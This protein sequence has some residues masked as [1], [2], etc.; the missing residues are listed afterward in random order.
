MFQAE[1]WLGAVFACLAC[2]LL[3]HVAAAE[4]HELADRVTAAGQFSADALCMQAELDTAQWFASFDALQAAAVISACDVVPGAGA[5][6]GAELSPQQTHS[7][8]I[9]TVRMQTLKKTTSDSSMPSSVHSASSGSWRWRAELPISGGQSTAITAAATGGTLPSALWPKA[10][11]LGTELTTND[12]IV[13]F[14]SPVSGSEQGVSLAALPRKCAPS[15]QLCTVTAA[16]VR[17]APAIAAAAPEIIGGPAKFWHVVPVGDVSHDGMPDIGVLAGERVLLQALSPRDTLSGRVQLQAALPS[18]PLDSHVLVFQLN[19]VS[20][21]NRPDA[22][23]GANL[24]IKQATFAKGAANGHAINY[25]AP[26]G[27]FLQQHSP[28]KLIVLFETGALKSASLARLLEDVNTPA[29]G[30]STSAFRHL[31]QGSGVKMTFFVPILAS[32]SSEFPV[33]TVSTIQVHSLAGLCSSSLAAAL[34]AGVA[35]RHAMHLP[36]LP[37]QDSGLVHAQSALVLGSAPFTA[38]GAPPASASGRPARALSSNPRKAVALTSPGDVDGDGQPDLAFIVASAE[39]YVVRVILSRD[40]TDRDSTDAAGSSGWRALIGS[41]G[42]IAVLDSA[43]SHNVVDFSDSQFRATVGLLPAAV[44]PLSTLGLSTSPALLLGNV[45]SQQPGSISQLY[46]AFLRWGFVQGGSPVSALSVTPLCVHAPCFPGGGAEE[47]QVL[48]A[49]PSGSRSQPAMFISVSHTSVTFGLIGASL[50]Q[51]GAPAIVHNGTWNQSDITATGSSGSVFRVAEGSLIGA[52]IPG[53]INGNG[54]PDVVL[55]CNGAGA[56]PA[57]HLVIMAMGAHF[58]PPLAFDLQ[59]QG[60]VVRG[61]SILMAAPASALAAAAGEPLDG[62]PP[63]VSPG[64]DVDGDGTPDLLMAFSSKKETVFGALLLQPSLS[65]WSVLHLDTSTR[66]ADSIATITVGEGVAQRTH[67]ALA[68]QASGKHARLALVSATAGAAGSSGFLVGPAPHTAA[69]PRGHGRFLSQQLAVLKADSMLEG[70]MYGD[71]FTYAGPTAVGPYLPDGSRFLFVAQPHAQDQFGEHGTIVLHRVRPAL[72]TQ[73]GT[74]VVARHV[75][76]LGA[77]GLGCFPVNGSGMGTSMVYLGPWGPSGSEALLAGAPAW[78]AGYGGFLVIELFLDINYELQY[79]RSVPAHLADVGVVKT[80]DYGQYAGRALSVLDDLNADGTQEVLFSAAGDPFS[81]CGC[82]GHFGIT[83]PRD[84]DVPGQLYAWDL[85]YINSTTAGLQGGNRTCFGYSLTAVG[86]VSGDGMVDFVVAAP[87]AVP[88]SEQLDDVSLPQGVLVLAHSMTGGSSGSPCLEVLS[89][90]WTEIAAVPLG[91]MGQSSPSEHFHSLFLAPIDAAAPFHRFTVL[92]GAASSVYSTLLTLEV[93]QSPGG[94]L[95]AVV[96]YMQSTSFLS[97][98]WKLGAVAEQTY[99]SAGWAGTSTP[100]AAFQLHD[101]TLRVVFGMLDEFASLEHTAV[102]PILPQPTSTT[103]SSGGVMLAKS[104]A[105]QS[106]TGAGG[107]VGGTSG[108]FPG[109]KSSSKVQMS[110]PSGGSAGSGG[111]AAKSTTTSS[112]GDITPTPTQPPVTVPNAPP[113]KPPL[114]DPGAPNT[115]APEDDFV[116]TG[117]SLRGM[118][119]NTTVQNVLDSQVENGFLLG[120]G[121]SVAWLGPGPAAGGVGTG[122]SDSGGDWAWLAVGSNGTLSIHVVHVPSLVVRGVLPV[123]HLAAGSPTWLAVVNKIFDSG[124]VNV[125][126][127]TWGHAVAPA[128]DANGDGVP[129]LIMAG[130]QDTVLLELDVFGS[131]L[132]A[133]HIYQGSF[134]SEELR[135]GRPTVALIA[136]HGTTP[137]HVLAVHTGVADLC[138]AANFNTGVLVLTG[139]PGQPGLSQALGAELFGFGEESLCEGFGTS[140]TSVGDFNR[141]GVPDIA[142]LNGNTGLV[143]LPLLMVSTPASGMVKL[144]ARNDVLPFLHVAASAVS[145]GTGTSAFGFAG[146]LTALASADPRHPVHLLTGYT[147]SQGKSGLAVLALGTHGITGTAQ[148]ILSGSATVQRGVNSSAAVFRHAISVFGGPD[149]SVLLVTG[150]P[151]SGNGTVKLFSLPSSATS[152]FMSPLLNPTT[153]SLNIAAPTATAISTGASTW[154]PDLDG[155]G[156]LDLVTGHP[157]AAGTGDFTGLATG[158]VLVQLLEGGLDVGGLSEQIDLS[159]FKV[160]KAG[161]IDPSNLGE[162]AGAEFGASLTVLGDLGWGPAPEILVGAPGYKGGAGCVFLVS[163]DL[164]DGALQYAVRR[165]AA[166]ADGAFG[167]A[168]AAVSV[169]GGGARVFISAPGAAN[170]AGDIFKLARI[171]VSPVPAGQGA[172]LPAAVHAARTQLA[173]LPSDV[174]DHPTFGRTLAV[175]S[176]GLP[177][178][179][180]AILFVGVPAYSSHGAIVVLRSDAFGELVS[181]GVAGHPTGLILPSSGRQGPP[182]TPFGAS[183]AL[184]GQVHT[185]AATKVTLVLGSEDASP[186]RSDWLWVLQLDLLP[187][188]VPGGLLAAALRPLELPLGATTQGIS[189]QHLSATVAP[190]GQVQL[191]AGVRNGSDSAAPTELALV[192]LPMFECNSAA[193][194][195]TSLHGG[196]VTLHPG[197]GQPVPAGTHGGAMTSP[198]DIDADGTL[199]IV[200]SGMF[201][202]GTWYISTAFPGGGV[203]VITPLEGDTAFLGELD[204]QDWAD[205]ASVNQLA[206][207]GDVNKDGV[208]DVLMG[209]R[210]DGR[211]AREGAVGIAF[212][213][214]DGMVT[215]ITAI[216]RPVVLPEAEGV[217]FSDSSDAFDGMMGAG[218]AVASLWDHEGPGQLALAVAS[219]FGSEC[220]WAV[221]KYNHGSTVDWETPSHQH[222]CPSAGNGTAELGSAL[223]LAWLPAGA[224]LSAMNSRLLPGEGVLV[225]AMQPL[226]D[227]FQPGGSTVVMVPIGSDLEP[228]VERSWTLTPAWGSTAFPHLPAGATHQVDFGWVLQAADV[229]SDGVLDLVTNIR[230]HTHSAATQL[231]ENLPGTAVL[232]L[233]GDGSLR[234]TIFAPMDSMQLSSASVDIAPGGI[235][236]LPGTPQRVPMAFHG[237]AAPGASRVARQALLGTGGAWRWGLRGPIVTAPG[238][239]SGF[240]PEGDGGTSSSPGTNI[241]GIGGGLGFVPGTVEGTTVEGGKSNGGGVP[242]FAPPPGGSAGGPFTAFGRSVA[243]VSS[244][245]DELTVAFATLTGIMYVL[246]TA[247]VSMATLLSGMP[248]GSATGTH[249]RTLVSDTDTGTQAGGDLVSGDF[250]GD[251]VVDFAQA[252]EQRLQFYTSIGGVSPGG[253]RLS[254]HNRAAKIGATGDEQFISMVSYKACSSVDRIAVLRL[255]SPSTKVFA[256]ELYRPVASVELLLNVSMFGNTTDGSLANLGWLPGW[257]G[258]VLAV[259]LNTGASIGYGVHL[260]DT[261]NHDQ[262]AAAF[263]TAFETGIPASTALAGL[264]SLGDLTGDG[265]PE[266]AVSSSNAGSVADSLLLLQM[267]SPPLDGG[268]AQA[269][270]FDSFPIAGASAVDADPPTDG[271]GS[272]LQAF[273]LPS[274]K[275]GLLVGAPAA[276]GGGGRVHFIATDKIIP[277]LA[278]TVPLLTVPTLGAGRVATAVLAHLQAGGTRA[279][280]AGLAINAST[281][282]QLAPS[283]HV[284]LAPREVYSAQLAL[285]SG[286]TQQLAGSD[287]AQSPTQEASL[288]RPIP[289]VDGDGL[290]EAVL[291]SGLTVSLHMSSRPSSELTVATVTTAGFSTAGAETKSRFPAAAVMLQSALEGTGDIERGL[292]V[293]LPEASFEDN[294]QAGALAYI[295]LGADG[296]LGQAC[297]ALYSIGNRG[298]LGASLLQLPAEHNGDNS[299]TA[300]IIVGAPGLSKGNGSLFA[301]YMEWANGNHHIVGQGCFLGR[302]LRKVAV[303]NILQGKPYQGVQLSG[304]GSSLLLLG[305]GADGA[306]QVLVGAHKTQPLTS[307]T[308]A[309]AVVLLTLQGRGISNVSATITALVLPSSTIHPPAA[310]PSGAVGGVAAANVMGAADL[311]LTAGAPGSNTAYLWALASHANET[312]TAARSQV[313]VAQLDTTGLNT[314]PQPSTAV[315]YRPAAPLAATPSASPSATSIAIGTFAPSGTPSPSTGSSPGSTITASPTASLSPGASPSTTAVP[316]PS[317][318]PAPLVLDTGDFSY[319]EERWWAFCPDLVAPGRPNATERLQAAGGAGV[320]VAVL[321]IGVLPGFWCPGCND[322]RAA[323]GSDEVAMCPRV[324][325]CEVGGPL[326]QDMRC[327]PGHTGAGCAACQSGWVPQDGSPC[328][329]CV[330]CDADSTVVVILLALGGAFVFGVLA[331]LAWAA[332]VVRGKVSQDLLFGALRIL[333]MYASLL[334]YIIAAF[335]PAEEGSL[336]MR[337]RAIHMDDWYEA[338]GRTDTNAHRQR[339]LASLTQDRS[340]ST[341]WLSD[342][343][344]YPDAQEETAAGFADDVMQFV[345]GISGA[346]PVTST[347]LTGCINSHQDFE[348]SATLNTSLMLGTFGVLLCIAVGFWLGK[349]YF[350]AACDRPLG[351]KPTRENVSSR[352]PSTSATANPMFAAVVAPASATANPMF[353]GRDGRKQIPVLSGT[354]SAAPGSKSSKENKN[355]EKPEAEKT[356]WT[357]R[358]LAWAGARFLAS[359]YLFLWAGAISASLQVLAP[360]LEAGDSSWVTAASLAMDINT[361]QHLVVLA[362]AAVAVFGFVIPLGL[363]AYLRGRGITVLDANSHASVTVAILTSGYRLQLTPVETRQLVQVQM[364]ASKAGR[365]LDTDTNAAVY[366][367]AQEV[368]RRMEARCCGLAKY[369]PSHGFA[370]VRQIQTVLVLCALWLLIEPISRAAVIILALAAAVALTYVLQPYALPELNSLDMQASIAVAIHVL[371]L[372]PGGWPHLNAVVWVMHA[373]TALLLALAVLRGVSQKGREMLAYVNTMIKAWLPELENDL[374]TADAADASSA[375]AAQDA[376]LLNSASPSPLA[377]LRALLVKLG[378]SALKRDPDSMRAQRGMSRMTSW[379][380][381]AEGA[382]AAI[383]ASGADSSTA[384]KSTGRK[385]N[386]AGGTANGVSRQ[387]A[388]E[389]FLESV[390]GKSSAKPDAVSSQ[391]LALAVQQAT[392]KRHAPPPKPTPTQSSAAGGQGAYKGEKD[393]PRKRLSLA[394][395]HAPAGGPTSVLFQRSSNTMA[396]MRTE[397][398]NA[399]DI[400]LRR[401]NAEAPTSVFAPTRAGVRSGRAG[402][403]R[404]RSDSQVA[405]LPSTGDRSHSTAELYPRGYS[406]GMATPASGRR[407]SAIDNRG[408]AGSVRI[409]PAGSSRRGTKG[410]GA[411]G[412]AAS[413]SSRTVS[414][415]RTTSGTL[416]SLQ[417]AAQKSTAGATARSSRRMGAGGNGPRRKHS[418]AAEFMDE[419]SLEV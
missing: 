139:G 129:D 98:A 155:N 191:A 149:G 231:N 176:V 360:R 58:T 256:L 59:T 3:S 187:G 326:Q 41:P 334:T 285:P 327:A 378:C 413:A 153:F 269:P 404:G 407:G 177:S 131:L 205:V 47:G 402:S 64:G 101:G 210:V 345:G 117:G 312:S 374:P 219:T 216:Q 310:C 192:L 53:D 170:T 174:L 283:L 301:F 336:G 365:K 116:I 357:V 4:S 74:H 37:R 46:V 314:D 145:F 96:E 9:C 399:E 265:M 24:P 68:T 130:P 202:D 307:G 375:E 237:F 105:K 196:Q 183:M 178:A 8:V 376:Q 19:T 20:T 128:G 15:R 218:M 341:T 250:N 21:K 308:S 137:F 331:Y 316:T 339:V 49:V 217:S 418:S 230:M 401:S 271:F 377:L 364:V 11:I 321:D 395:V 157:G 203:D 89:W 284:L 279:Y 215:S 419:A 302:R 303:D 163:L 409:A 158:T 180:N 222:A 141:D 85:T 12:I 379:K 182:P 384:G 298:H 194:H 72:G 355:T 349:L 173:D 382:V 224:L 416:R 363:M 293:G 344:A 414:V 22:E 388:V 337:T 330:R 252:F 88:A 362:V 255:F 212:L 358:V 66:G 84:G 229:D 261:G 259:L 403:V 86:D 247:V 164:A 268:I 221:S 354:S 104:S 309:G 150:V 262:L 333:G 405:D 123:S 30:S 195:A 171:F 124:D 289:D 300:V 317:A 184:A 79:G 94:E 415:S 112:G 304:L 280:V 342:A 225:F 114:S 18:P 111:T 83:S 232:F 385:G 71:N 161:T 299:N 69:T 108:L 411:D 297:I 386:A 264:V 244:V 80:G 292:L 396:S 109:G 392:A 394:T 27:A 99:G 90:T 43:G 91:L 152:P 119:T 121:T 35:V 288:W 408:R 335:A 31:P 1:C 193:G 281:A 48:A 254:S 410:G 400:E 65:G 7:S 246:K 78:D 127:I 188:P 258:Q 34:K 324:G 233:A 204:S 209:F 295:P 267:Q 40:S 249:V 353:A 390:A 6:F 175:T 393:T 380:A 44:A 39:W 338:C 220:R 134:A 154:L 77:H 100:R 387:S 140:V 290:P 67:I 263:T 329:P 348:R 340:N 238:G 107:P 294:P 383:D 332:V 260:L 206:P 17:F 412:K 76:Q 245:G 352:S 306:T 313:F 214:R 398:T 57:V 133:S 56:S 198:G 135:Q 373:I 113:M 122:G 251:G 185:P 167:T 270:R 356:T 159:L 38:S 102:M 29:A 146:S 97:P 371:V 274:G 143:I 347:A 2:V 273:Q 381:F 296:I 240:A 278:S 359:I 242:P 282:G 95:A 162:V 52:T 32:D 406:F 291:V 28:A 73:H 87:G 169:P 227:A 110:V 70:V 82:T 106:S 287:G 236:F 118:T 372:V 165:N 14:S 368:S 26:V 346:L 138:S 168:V 54:V 213:A 50:I 92:V 201:P 223:S 23:A 315:L 144:E 319:C 151:S 25:G 361:V 369:I 33:A 257:S 272:S 125:G 61:S 126:S 318:T 234:R 241:G 417:A 286:A 13:A 62:G 142:V 147:S 328:A 226:R 190:N 160:M 208:P 311:A 156:F 323:Y 322:A 16:A 228:H 132:N 166:V 243:V 181:F 55:V 266:L 45:L 235:V 60:T 120:L 211:V 397:L 148:R 351:K 36:T 253:R 350:P 239:K 42:D 200:A 370:L 389:A 325:A 51:Q 179:N 276:D 103:I 172:G 63:L 10:T 75:L 320:R 186:A 277:Q 248:L 136:E 391:Q 366:K 197:A 305:R 367:M 81:A 207:V 5:D 275:L 343:A 93:S 199:D 189:V 115:F